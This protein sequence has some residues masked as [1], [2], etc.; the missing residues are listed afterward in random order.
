[1]RKG[2]FKYIC[3]L[4]FFWKSMK[5]IW[6]HVKICCQIHRQL[7]SCYFLY[8]SVYLKYWLYIRE[9]QNS[10][11]PLYYTTGL[12]SYLYGPLAAGRKVEDRRPLRSKTVFLS[13]WCIQNTLFTNAWYF[14]K[15]G[16]KSSHIKGTYLLWELCCFHVLFFLTVCSR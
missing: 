15:E 7:A 14:L 5:Q 2:C 13:I 4:Y 10:G 1:M 6:Q 12:P 11:K 9:S 3:N 8:F 16:K